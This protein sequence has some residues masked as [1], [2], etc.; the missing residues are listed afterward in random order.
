MKI[1]LRYGKVE[2]EAEGAIDEVR[3]F[4]PVFEALAL[5][6]LRLDQ[7]ITDAATQDVR[8]RPTVH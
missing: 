2:I 8:A 7:K 1:R 6:K 3:A 5:A 4:V